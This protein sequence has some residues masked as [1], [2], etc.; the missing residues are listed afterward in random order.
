MRKASINDIW[1]S[2][3]HFTYY[4]AKFLGKDRLFCLITISKFG[5]FQN[6]FVT[7]TSLNFTLVTEDLFGFFKHKKPFLPVMAAEKAAKNHGDEWDL[8]WYLQWG[9]YIYINSSLNPLTSF[10]SSSRKTQF[11]VILPRII[12]LMI[13]ETVPISTKISC[14]I[15]RGIPFGLEAKSI[16]TET[17]T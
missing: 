5:N 14:V 15:K 7:I 16:E 9:I 1:C 13:T 6:P 4:W 12:S 10:S 17:P 2:V 8:T 11:K 3:S